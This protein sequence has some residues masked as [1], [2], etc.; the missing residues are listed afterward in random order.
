[1][2]LR[3]AVTLTLAGGHHI[4]ATTEATQCFVEVPIQALHRRD[5]FLAREQLAQVGAGFLAALVI[6]ARW[7]LANAQGREGFLLALAP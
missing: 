5:R 6:G 4:Q 3:Q 7:Q 2:A 1:M